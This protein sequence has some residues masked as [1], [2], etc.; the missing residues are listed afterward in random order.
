[1][2]TASH[3]SDPGAKAE[4]LGAQL[5]QLQAAF[6]N[7]SE[8]SRLLEAVAREISQLRYEKT[9]H[10]R[11][12]KT[13]DTQLRVLD[14]ERQKFVAVV[15]QTD[16]YVC[17][18][19]AE[20]R[21]LWVNHAMSVRLD[22]E[23][24]HGRERV[25]LREALARIGLEEGELPEIESTLGRA[26]RENVAVHAELHQTRGGER[27]SL[28]LTG[29]PIL[30][31]D[32]SPDE[33]LVLLQDLSDL[34]VLR[35]SEARYRLLFEQSP[36]AMVMVDPRTMRI[37]LANPVA[38]RLTGWSAE[39]L[40]TLSIDALHDADDWEHSKREL[41]RVAT[42]EEATFGECVLISK[43]GKHIQA[44]MSATRFD[45][46]GRLVLLVD[47]QDQT[48]RK[49]LEAELRQSH[50]ME[51]IGRLAG[52]V[53]HDFNNLLTVILGQSEQLAKRLDEEPKL[54]AQAE[55]IQKA[56]FRGSLLTRQLLAFGRKEVLQTIVLD[57]NDVLSDLETLL[58]RLIGEDLNFET[59]LSHEPC[60]VRIDRGQIEQVIMNLAVNAR[61]AMPV[62]GQC[63]LEVARDHVT[64]SV[65]LKVSDTG[66][67]M[68]AETMAHVFEP[69]FTTKERGK[70]TGL[71]LSTAYAIVSEYSGRI[72]VTSAVGRGTTFTITFPLATQEVRVPK[73][74]PVER[75]GS[76]SGTETILLVEDEP[77]LRMMAAQA[78]E[79]SNYTVIE[80]SCGE[81]ALE[82]F[83]DANRG[84]DLLLTDVIMPGIGGGELV[85]R[86]TQI[87]P[88]LRVL[89][90][91]GYTD[92]SVVRHGVSD[93]EVAFLQK[94][95]TLETLSRRVREVLDA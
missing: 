59:K 53:A 31:P 25:A 36:D 40:L 38:S 17:V 88:Q 75:S 30:G 95:F 24:E 70:G 10:E 22:P 76:T 61:D 68:D 85:K 39:E 34:D 23:E 60:W 78:L 21:I 19:D 90:M 92:D 42:H 87:R 6:P 7:G 33:V 1:M 14:R 51:A 37:V 29:L 2:T 71:G 86:A 64:N 44:S 80:A 67:G 41:N 48:K 74:E 46:D 18:V 73:S 49:R 5:K 13:L 69:F 63:I 62:G 83:S 56:A 11:W 54:R 50:K 15:N 4:T 43:Q 84:I 57:L 72:E 12:F 55:S 79:L 32:G 3:A 94:P 27:R 28:Y 77:D 89:Y 66:C 81:E 16:T 35:K 8:Q 91:S 52:G 45:L 65:V 26:F 47:Y 20:Q 93:S 82:V 9:K 58:R